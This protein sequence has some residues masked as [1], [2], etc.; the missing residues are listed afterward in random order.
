MID[1]LLLTNIET[2]THSPHIVCLSQAY[3]LV[4]HT[5][6]L[7]QLLKEGRLCPVI[8]CLHIGGGGVVLQL[9]ELL[10]TEEGDRFSAFPSDTATGYLAHKTQAATLADFLLQKEETKRRYHTVCTVCVIS[11]THQSSGHGSLSLCLVGLLPLPHKD[12][13]PSLV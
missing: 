1:L 7:E 12:L 10:F 8:H 13:H 6:A 5:P 3:S 2:H 11:Y 9:N 4:L